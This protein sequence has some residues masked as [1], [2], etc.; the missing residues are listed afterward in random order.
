[1][2]LN[3]NLC[4]EPGGG[5]A[6]LA[7]GGINHY[8]KKPFW[9]VVLRVGPGVLDMLGKHSATLN[10]CY[11]QRQ[12]SCLLAQAGFRIVIAV[13]QP[14][15]KLGLWVCI[16]ISGPLFEKRQ[17]QLFFSLFVLSWFSYIVIWWFQKREKPISLIFLS[18]VLYSLNKHIGFR[19]YLTSSHY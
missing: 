15:E 2:Q 17:Q 11:V 7:F 6:L 10:N 9:D 5:K 18:V 12:R 4:I 19:L 14:P 3:L 16:T 1:M 8:R 13:L